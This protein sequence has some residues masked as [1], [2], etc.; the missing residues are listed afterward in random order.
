MWKEKVASAEYAFDIDRCGFRTKVSANKT[1]VGT[2]STHQG[3]IDNHEPCVI[4][5][6]RFDVSHATT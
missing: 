6:E 2:L 5:L 3:W 4:T 1:N